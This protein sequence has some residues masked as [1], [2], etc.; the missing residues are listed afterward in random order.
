MTSTEKWGNNIKSEGRIMIGRLCHI[1]NTP[2]QRRT[3]SGARFGVRFTLDLLY[4]IAK[5]IL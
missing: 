2:R 4:S 3:S 5:D 1:A